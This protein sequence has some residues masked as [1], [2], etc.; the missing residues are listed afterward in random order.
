[1]TSLGGQAVARPM[2]SQERPLAEEAIAAK[3]NAKKRKSTIRLLCVYSA[4]KSLAI[5]IS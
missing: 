5:A 1:M 3:R 4:R 2:A